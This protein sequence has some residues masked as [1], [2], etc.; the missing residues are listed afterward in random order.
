MC[1]FT[2]LGTSKSDNFRNQSLSIS[3][4]A[5]RSLRKLSH[6]KKRSLQKWVISKWFTSKMRRFGNE[7]FE[8]GLIRKMSIL[9]I[10]KKISFRKM[11]QF[12]NFYFA[13]KS[14]WKWATP[15]MSNSEMSYFGNESLGK[16][17]LRKWAT[18]QI[19][20]LRN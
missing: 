19:K 1:H 15:E 16:L 12:E 18:L 2:K 17:S 11:G 8:N 7:Q 5:L 14:L 6:Y 13:Y 10:D 20:S 4:R 3:S 9:E